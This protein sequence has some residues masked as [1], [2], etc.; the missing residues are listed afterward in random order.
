MT[1]SR[2]AGAGV[3]VALGVLEILAK[4]KEFGLRELAATGGWS[5]TTV[6]RVLT[7]LCQLGFVVQ[8]LTT[9]KYRIG[10]SS[11]FLSMEILSHQSLRS[12]SG[13]LLRQLARE[14]GCTIYLG[15]LRGQKV[16]LVDRAQP[17]ALDEYSVVAPV[18]YPIHVTSM[19]K[20]IM[21]HLPSSEREAILSGYEFVPTSDHAIRS[22]EE[23]ER[24]LERVRSVGYAVNRRELDHVSLSVAV[25]VFEDNRV[26]AALAADVAS[27][28]PQDDTV[29]EIVPVLQ[30]ASRRIGQYLESVR[31]IAPRDAGPKMRRLVAGAVKGGSSTG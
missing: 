18:E 3:E 13:P 8:D 14:T 5:K 1:A 16:F 4:G 22:R 19:G 9:R 30:S 10:P 11:I 12:A 15:Q 2:G 23:Y 28:H 26:I 21:A 27:I 7:T 17:L 29:H 6:H 31:V 20:A 25:P 24:E